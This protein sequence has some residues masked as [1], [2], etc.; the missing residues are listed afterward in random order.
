MGLLTLSAGVITDATRTTDAEGDGLTPP[1]GLGVWPGATNICKYSNQVAGPGTGWTNLGG[2]SVVTF[3]IR[4]DLFTPMYFARAVVSASNEGIQ[5]TGTTIFAAIAA[6]TQYTLSVYMDIPVG[7]TVTLQWNDYDAGAGFL[8]AHSTNC[9]GT[10]TLTRYTLTATT[11]A[12]TTQMNAYAYSASGAQTFEAGAWQMEL[13]SFATPYIATDA[14][15]TASRVAGRIRQTVGDLLTEQQG[16]FA[17]RVRMGWANTAR[18][19]TDDAYLYWR[20]FD[21]SNYIFIGYDVSSATWYCTRS[22]TSGADIAGSA[23]TFANGDY[24]T[25]IGQLTAGQAKISIDGAAFTAGGTGN[26]PDLSSVTQADIASSGSSKHLGGDVRWAVTGSGLLTDADAAAIAALSNMAPT[27]SDV[28]SALSAGAEPTSVITGESDGFYYDGLAA[29]T[30]IAPVSGPP[31]ANTAVSITGTNFAE[32]VAITVNG[33]AA[34]A[35]TYVD[36]E[37]ITA[38]MPRNPEGTYPVV[39]TTG[40]GDT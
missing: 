21:G 32:P 31:N 2:G 20:A 14:N 16:W 33:N 40:N 1:A 19:G 7:E 39:I 28:E 10:G 11:N 15:A 6:T 8:G 34:T 27:L 13:G 36:H 26:I 35:V 29:A 22:A 5:T 23:D 24:V 4:S 25:V 12:T 18:T 3:V 30:A 9:A 37:T 17:A 38:T